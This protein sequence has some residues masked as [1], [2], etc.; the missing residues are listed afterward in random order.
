ME[1][2]TGSLILGV[3]TK[4]YKMTNSMNESQRLKVY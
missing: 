4:M 2:V 1:G 3:K